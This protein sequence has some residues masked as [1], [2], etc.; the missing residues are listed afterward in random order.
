[1]R[2]VAE[3]GQGV[4][5]SRI[6]QDFGV[7][8]ATLHNWIR[9]ADGTERPAKTPQ[10]ATQAELVA[11]R[12][13]VRQLEQKNEVLRRAAAYLSQANLP[14]KGSPR[15]SGELANDG[16]PIVVTLR[17]LKL[18]RSA[19]Y[20]WCEQPVTDTE[21]IQAY[22]MNSL[23]DAHRDDLEFG[24]RFLADEAANKGQPMGRRTAWKLCSKQQWH[25]IV[26]RS[27]GKR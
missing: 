27:K 8:R 16:I 19:H 15:R 26:A 2:F 1:M 25:S 4:S 6:A 7:S 21:W 18:S 10:S 20:R 13:R 9:A 5:M 17:V 24:Y 23:F 12:K 3:Q 14:L 11:A 22:R